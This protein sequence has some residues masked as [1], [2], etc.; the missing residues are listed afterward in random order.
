MG[1]RD[2]VV[3]HL[4]L[5]QVVQAAATAQ[6]L[7]AHLHIHTLV[8]E[9][10]GGEEPSVGGRRLECLVG[11]VVAVVVV[12]LLL[13]LSGWSSRAWWKSRLSSAS[14]PRPK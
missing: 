9:P 4:Q 13:N 14:I 1:E 7:Q 12:Y 11:L 8:V 10:V 3:V 2:V 5:Q 6:L